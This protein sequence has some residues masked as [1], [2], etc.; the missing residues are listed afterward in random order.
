L[1]KDHNLGIKFEKNPNNLGLIESRF[2]KFIKIQKEV[3]LPSNGFKSIKDL[4]DFYEDLIR[5]CLYFELRRESIEGSIARMKAWT[6]KTVPF[7]KEFSI[8]ARIQLEEINKL[9]EFDRG[10]LEVIKEELGRIYNT[11]ALIINIFVESMGVDQKE[12]I[13]LEE[14]YQHTHPDLLHGGEEG[15]MFEYE[16]YLDLRKKL[17]VVLLTFGTYYEPAKID[18]LCFNV[19]LSGKRKLLAF[20][21][22]Q[23]NWTLENQLVH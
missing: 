22:D 14:K 17:N 15:W 1:N 12:I 23:R 20:S 8:P 9:L 21:K 19:Q 10:R 13:S 6:N 18:F 3:L 11:N 5:Y 7:L 16:T 2:R 4:M